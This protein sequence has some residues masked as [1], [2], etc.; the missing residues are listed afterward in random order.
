MNTAES[1]DAFAVTVVL[2]RM[3]GGTN[4]GLTM[5]VTVTRR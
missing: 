3:C 4:T 2:V 5:P 1:K